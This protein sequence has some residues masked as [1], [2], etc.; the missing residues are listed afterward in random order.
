MNNFY[1]LKMLWTYGRTYP[2]VK[3]KHYQISSRARA[4]LLVTYVTPAMLV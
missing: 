4:C 1:K 2:I 3:N